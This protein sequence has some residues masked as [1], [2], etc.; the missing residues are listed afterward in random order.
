[1]PPPPAPAAR[2]IALVFY[3][4]LMG[5]STMDAGIPY[6]DPKDWSD[7]QKYRGAVQHPASLFTA[8]G[9][10]NPQGTDNFYFT[11]DLTTSLQSVPEPSTMALCAMALVTV[12]CWRKRKGHA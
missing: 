3:A 10:N 12:G 8:A 1:M 4:L 9:I 11:Q 2:H 5:L 6:S 7:W